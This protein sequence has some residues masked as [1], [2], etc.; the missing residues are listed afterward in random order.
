MDVDLLQSSV[1][2]LRTRWPGAKP[3]H[4][5]ICGSGWSE[6]VDAF[7]VED[8]ISYEDIP[9]LGRTTVVGHAGQVALGRL[10]GLETV[11]FQGRR[12][13]Y[14]GAGWTPVAIPVHLAV[15]LGAG[16]MVLTN[17]AGGVREDLRPGDLMA[18]V[19]HINNMG[20]N[21]LIGEHLPHWGPRF[22]DMSAAYHPG[23]WKR[24]HY[25]A[26]VAGIGLRPG[27]YLANSGPTYETPAEVRMAQAMGADAVGMSTVPEA[28]LANAA[29]LRVAGISCITNLAAGFG[30]DAL[31][32]EE[33][34]ASTAEAMPRMRRLLAAFWETM[35]EDAR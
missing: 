14:E 22:P 32:H 8:T 20:A 26:G 2:A 3:S 17:S 16:T 35:A 31:T 33:V 23:L 29:G 28:I 24:L 21:P 9:G 27:V 1:A 34:T 6:V 19:D 18:I 11:V 25:A 15:Q 10:A 13:Y 7:T 12:H 30:A 5:L 4:A